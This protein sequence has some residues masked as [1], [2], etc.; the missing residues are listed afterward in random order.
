MDLTDAVRA[1]IVRYC[2][3][4]RKAFPSARWV[5]PDGM[6]VTL[7]F[8]GEVNADKVHGIGAALGEIRSP[9]P[10]DMTFQ[11]VG[12]FPTER[13]PRVFWIGIA[14]SPNLAE[15]AAGIESRLEPLGITGETRAFH[16]H[17]TLARLEDS[18]GVEKLHAA[19]RGAGPAEF[20]DVR[21][22]EM[23]LYQS[24]LKPGGAQYAR[25]ASFRLAP[26]AVA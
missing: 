22:S 7:K 17:L 15:I 11:G 3:G 19:I 9:L 26:E 2:D 21:A 25:L 13:R 14:H 12:F 23:H 6:H 18:R 4:L 1:A 16:P 10:V 24:E 5:K 20:G 8:I